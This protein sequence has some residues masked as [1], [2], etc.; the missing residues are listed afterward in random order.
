MHNLT[1]TKMNF[2]DPNVKLSD[3]QLM[4]LA[5]W[6]SHEEVRVEEVTK[7]MTREEK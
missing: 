5:S 1:L 2:W 6:M 7:V 3:L 4:A